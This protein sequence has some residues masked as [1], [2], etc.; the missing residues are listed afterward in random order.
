M[1]GTVLQIGTLIHML[2][3][4]YIVGGGIYATWPTASS[5]QHH[6]HTAAA[7]AALAAATTTATTPSSSLALPTPPCR[8]P[9]SPVPPS[10]SRPP[11]C[12]LALHPSP[13]SNSRRLW[14]VP[15]VVG[16]TSSFVTGDLSPGGGT[17]ATT[18]S[19]RPS[20]PERPPP[21]AAINALHHLREGP[22]QK[23]TRIKK[24]FSQ[25]REQRFDLGGGVEAFKGVWASAFLKKIVSFLFL[26]GVLGWSWVALVLN[27][28]VHRRSW[29]HS[30]LKP[31]TGHSVHCAYCKLSGGSRNVRVGPADM[32]LQLRH[33]SVELSRDNSTKENG[34]L[35][36][37]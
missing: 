34:M 25:R 13:K 10:S 28:L 18:R 37:H 19:T 12:P 17:P 1:H 3:D 20:P 5:R 26:G 8:R 35:R 36:Y 32:F 4:G 14:R 11:A 30:P 21:P 33:Q 16:P 2:H 7:A 27:W 24:S 22:S 15:R 23:Y 6:L 9:R 31:F 29:Y